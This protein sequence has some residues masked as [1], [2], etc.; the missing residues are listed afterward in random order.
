MSTSNLFVRLLSLVFFLTL[1]PASVISQV[2]DNIVIEGA[3]FNAVSKE[4][5][6][7]ATISLPD[8]R[9]GTISNI[10]GE[11]RIIIPSTNKSDS[12]R[13]SYVGFKSIKHKISEI[14]NGAQ[15]FLVEDLQALEEVVI[16]GLT[17]QAILEKAI[18]KIPDNYYNAPYK[19]KGFY[20]L[21]AKKDEQYIRLSE[22]AFELYHS[23]KSTNGN[24]FKLDKMREIKDEQ[25]L[26]NISFGNSPK[27][28]F[29]RDVINN[30]DESDFLNKKGIKNHTFA[31]E[32]ISS[33]NDREVYVISFDQKDGIKKVGYRGKLVIDLETFAFIHLDFEMSPKSIQYYK[34]S[35]SQRLLMKLLDIHA[36]LLKSD[37]Q[38]NYKKIG[39]KYYLSSAHSY[40]KLS[41]QSSRQQFDFKTDV[42][43][44]YLI[45]T[46]E[47]EN[48]QPFE[49]EEVLGKNKLI[50]NQNSIY[51]QAF[52]T[53]HTVILPDFDFETIAKGIAIRSRLVSHPLDTSS[54][55]N[56]IQDYSSINSIDQ[57]AEAFKEKQ[58]IPGL[59]LAIMKDDSLVYSDAFGYSDKINEVRATANTQFRIA[60][61]SKTL[62]SAGLIKLV[63]Q[64]KVDLDK[65][66]RHYVP[67]FP[68]K[69]HPITVR[70]LMGHLGGIR[71]YYGKSW[72]EELFIQD[73]YNNS[74][75][76]ISIFSDDAL[77]AEPGTQFVYSSFGYM[78]LGAVIES[79][80]NLSYLEYMSTA[81][82]NPLNMDFT[83]GD[84]ADSTMT[85]KS[86]F[87]FFPGEEEATPYDLSYSYPSG[88]LVSTAED[89][90]NFGFAL[91][92][93]KLFSDSVREQVFET[94][95]TSN[96]Q[97][98]G[99]GL[100]WYIGE[101]LNGN[102]VWYH[103][104]ELPSSG[105]MLMI[106]P[107]RKLVIALLTNSPIIS[108][109]DGFS[110]EIQK[111]TEMALTH[112]GW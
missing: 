40:S 33:Y 32:L 36:G 109:A 25:L 46:I 107:D 68:Q 43:T 98:T 22:A 48:Q 104:G 94:Q 80:S 73:H 75:E 66:V 52:W 92:E 63:S 49:D 71:D 105:S 87:Y 18:Q 69:K 88:G 6:P 31:L 91:L 50:E 17:A 19:S 58:Y 65:S 86:R 51:D 79:A 60:S 97:P 85:H 112:K 29:G 26:R 96:G 7:F 2:N 62:T 24:Q 34:A 53:D 61:I 78:L 21:T 101:D 54:E 45:T 3:I 28:I 56:T 103:A 47:T 108:E 4:P 1:Y 95:Y 77:V 84:I 59:Q 37:M 35:A 83:Y 102:K 111:L 81:I 76:A 100:G 9:V 67:S 15:F 55:K 14:A 23:E 106:Y 12:L 8:N 110:D 16:T 41:F 57:W 90:V 30:L 89:L 20:R 13:I 38:I 11:F 99:Y 70:Q 74:T 42:Q 10:K 72:E 64:D 93:N 27:G 44:D 39:D 82:W 5:L